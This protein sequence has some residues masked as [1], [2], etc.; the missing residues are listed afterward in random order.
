MLDY[1]K[2][3]SFRDYVA[4]LNAFYLSRKEL[5]E[6]DFIEDGFKWIYADE[7]DKNIVAFKR[8]DKKG[9]A[10]IVLL[11][12]SGADQQVVIP[13][14]RGARLESLFDTGTLS[15]EQKN[16]KIRRIKGEYQAEVVIPAFSGAIYKV[17]SKNK[18]IKI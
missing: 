3:K 9:R 16:V 15:E 12:F 10:V 2:H 14:D 4:S 1:P 7:A 18:I 13:T 6:V 17:C 5:W 8:L 11:N